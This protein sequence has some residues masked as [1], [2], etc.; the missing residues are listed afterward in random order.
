MSV[1]VTA[2]EQ[3]MR[4]VLGSL[5][6]TMSDSLRLPE[7]FNYSDPAPDM[8]FLGLR[9]LAPLPGFRMILTVLVVAASLSRPRGRD[10]SA[11]GRP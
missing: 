11:R 8:R 1:S 9:G 10:A 7:G 5:R 6:Q 4:G 3:A 2:R